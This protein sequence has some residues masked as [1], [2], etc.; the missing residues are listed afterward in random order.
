MEKATDSPYQP[1]TADVR[2]QT[3]FKRPAPIKAVIVGLLVDQVGTA[4]FQLGLFV[5]YGFMLGA[6]GLQPKEIV[7]AI[8]SLVWYSGPHIIEFVGGLLISVLAGYLCARLARQ[9]IFRTTLIMAA[10]DVG[11]PLPF[12]H[13]LTV[14]K[15]VLL[16]APTAIC[17]LLGAWLW[18]LQDRRNGELPG[19]AL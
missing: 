5:V 12:I 6:E 8:N 15:L 13:D 11:L 4:I 2:D 10:L 9:R 19:H 3:V 7:Q 16:V 18:A 14:L 1:P 17:V